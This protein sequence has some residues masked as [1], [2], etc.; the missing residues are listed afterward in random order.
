MAHKKGEGSTQN[1]RD[2]IS[3]RLGVKLYGGQ[4][5]KAGNIIIKQRGTKFHPGQNTYLGKDFTLH[6]SILGKVSFTKGKEGRT[7]VHVLPFEAQVEETIAKIDKKA[8]KV[9]SAPAP[10]AKATRAKAATKEVV[11]KAPQIEA[12]VEVVDTE[13]FVPTVSTEEIEMDF[14]AA[15][16]EPVVEPVVEPIAESVVEAIA[17]PVVEAI[18]EPVVEAS[19]KPDD[20]KKIEGIGPKIAE[21]LIAEGIITFA[22]LAAASVERI[23]E[24]LDAAGPRYRVHNPSTWAQ[25]ADLAANGKWD[26]LDALQKE[27]DGGKA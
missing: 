6:A 20:L 21:L 7:F 8:P 25:Q 11:A 9:T 4:T 22:D 24:I 3:K 17:E 15:F 2:S 10:E 26:E 14:D 12:P 1:G 13:K 19:G 16:D 27:L 23:Q 5:A 18:A